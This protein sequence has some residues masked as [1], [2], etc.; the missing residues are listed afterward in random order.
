MTV[1][2]DP[3]KQNCAAEA[4]TCCRCRKHSPAVPPGEAS[5]SLACESQRQSK[6]SGNEEKWEGQQWEKEFV[7]IL[8]AGKI[9]PHRTVAV[10]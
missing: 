6:V 4:A 3:P 1:T 9:K 10:F 5:D 2:G 8:C 7:F